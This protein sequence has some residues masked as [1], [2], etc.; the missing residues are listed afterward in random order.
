MSVSPLIFLVFMMHVASVLAAGMYCI[1]V[2]SVLAGMNCCIVVAAISY[3][4][5]SSCLHPHQMGEEPPLVFLVGHEHFKDLIDAHI[6][7]LVIVQQ[8]Y[9]D[10]ENFP[11]TSILKLDPILQSWKRSL[12]HLHP[13]LRQLSQ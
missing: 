6:A 2:G 1:D 7:G 10:Q 9:C 5:K 8:D 3:L 11:F 4:T 12:D 13:P